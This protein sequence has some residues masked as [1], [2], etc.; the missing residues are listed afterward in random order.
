MRPCE[1]VRG[2]LTAYLK[3]L[4]LTTNTK[5]IITG[6]SLGAALAWMAARDLQQNENADVNLISFGEGSL[7]LACSGS[8]QSC[9]LA[10]LHAI[11]A[12]SGR[13][14]RCALTRTPCAVASSPEDLS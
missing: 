13:A 12:S 11:E 5:L 1:Q 4:G 7:A 2:R 8:V 10:S 14:M 6:H 3:T 9:T